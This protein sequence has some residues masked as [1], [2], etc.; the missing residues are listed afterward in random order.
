MSL[1][2]T[3]RRVHNERLVCDVILMWS[4]RDVSALDPRQETQEVLQQLVLL[5]A[6]AHVP[7]EETLPN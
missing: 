5:T 3:D 6:H 7:C 4:Q 2:L 1:C